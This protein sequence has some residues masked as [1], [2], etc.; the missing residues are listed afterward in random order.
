MFVILAPVR[1]DDDR[2]TSRLDRAPLR[3]RRQIGTRRSFPKSVDHRVAG[4]EHVVRRHV[5]LQQVL[6][7]EGRRRK[8]VGGDGRR[9]P[10]V[11]LF[12]VRHPAILGAQARLDVPDGNPRVEC[13][14]RRG[15]A[16]RRIAVHEHDVGPRFAQHALHA[17][18][19]RV[20]TS[21]SV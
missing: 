18:Q 11:H 13:G 12:G 3:R 7:R 14:Q 9:Q 17:D 15:R 1:G 5:F 20:V 21:V 16:R 2:R 19:P 10:P 8:M 6:A 4:D